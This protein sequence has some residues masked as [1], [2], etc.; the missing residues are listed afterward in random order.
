MLVDCEFMPTVKLLQ[1]RASGLER[2]TAVGKIGFAPL[3][4]IPFTIGKTT[5]PSPGGLAVV[6]ATIVT[7]Y[8][9]T[10]TRPVNA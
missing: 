4:A 5:S 8:S 1:T 6:G 10:K 9:I 2:K 7:V 3:L